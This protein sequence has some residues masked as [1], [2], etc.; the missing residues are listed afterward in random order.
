M[1]TDCTRGFQ[2]KVVREGLDGG[3]VAMTV[4]RIRRLAQG[5]LL[6]RHWWYRGVD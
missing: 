2:K 6:D 4:I 1:R 3:N 5:A